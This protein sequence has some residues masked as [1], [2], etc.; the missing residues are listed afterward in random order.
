MGRLVSFCSGET[1]ASTKTPLFLM[2]CESRITY[3]GK[4]RNGWSIIYS[5]AR[6]CSENRSVRF[7]RGETLY[8]VVEQVRSCCPQI[9]DYG[10]M[11]SSPE[12]EMELLLDYERTC[13]EAFSASPA[14]VTAA[15]QPAGFADGANLSTLVK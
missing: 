9:M 6:G 5:A 3:L 15:E 4:Y 8:R 12:T 7:G 13:M 14:A 1:S 11:I 10:Y 2:Y